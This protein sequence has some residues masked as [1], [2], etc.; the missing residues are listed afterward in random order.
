MKLENEFIPIL[1]SER[2]VL[3]PLSLKHLSKNYLNWLNDPEVNKFTEQ[4]FKKSSINDLQDYLK[5]VDEKKILFWAIKIKKNGKHIGNIKIDPINKIQRYGEYGILIGD[6]SCW[7]QGLAKEA[8]KRVIEYCFKNLKL[9][10]ITLGVIEDN[11]NAFFLYKKLG[12]KALKVS[13]GTNT[14]NNKVSNSIRMSLNVK[15]FKK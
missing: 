4:S 7:G 1:E 10:K 9:S 11:K 5:S 13:K 14:Y 6:K 3:E 12:F 2:L 15:D 8:S